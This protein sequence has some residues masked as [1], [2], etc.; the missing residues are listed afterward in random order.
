[1]KDARGLPTT[2][3]N[4]DIDTHCGSNQS[5]LNDRAC[6]SIWSHFVQ[7]CQIS[8]LQPSKAV[9]MEPFFDDNIFTGKPRLGTFVRLSKGE[10]TNVANNCKRDKQ[11]TRRD[12]KQHATSFPSPTSAVDSI[13]LDRHAHDMHMHMPHVTVELNFLESQLM[14]DQQWSQQTQ[15]NCKSIETCAAG[16][17]QRE[18]ILSQSQYYNQHASGISFELQNDH[19][20]NLHS[21]GDSAVT[22]TDRLL[23]RDWVPSWCRDDSHSSIAMSAIADEEDKK[24]FISPS[25]PLTVAVQFSASDDV[26][27]EYDGLY[28]ASYPSPPQVVPRLHLPSDVDKNSCWT[29]NDVGS[30]AL[31]GRWDTEKP[32]E[33]QSLGLNLSLDTTMELGCHV[34]VVEDFQDILSSNAFLASCQ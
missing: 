28:L 25:T 17:Q 12:K 13:A 33:L 7:F 8:S 30:S 21:G 6:F 22:D 5:N 11:Q 34:T 14:S 3:Q 9:E 27:S 24:K 20:S 32:W 4:Y 1:M 26:Y 29:E 31:H 16:S 10:P 18:C 19:Y 15:S 23:C 2:D